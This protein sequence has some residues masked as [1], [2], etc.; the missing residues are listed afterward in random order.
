MSCAFFHVLLCTYVPTYLHTY[1]RTCIRMY[2]RMYVHT[3]IRYIPFHIVSVWGKA[4][5]CHASKEVCAE[6][7]AENVI[8]S[9]TYIYYYIRRYVCMYVYTYVCPH[10]LLAMPA[11]TAP[12]SLYLSTSTSRRWLSWGR[13][14]AGSWRSWGH[15]WLNCRY[16]LWTDV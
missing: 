3:Y 9:R 1:V 7:G 12:P 2:V 15:H 14:T 6:Y 10:L 16:V 5:T 8:L 11:C 13:P 4:S